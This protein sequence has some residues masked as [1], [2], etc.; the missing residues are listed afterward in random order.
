VQQRIGSADTPIMA[1]RN[2]IIA[3]SLVTGAALELFVAAVSGRRE[4]WDSEQF[5]TMG[6]PAA[7]LAS[8]VIGFVSQRREWLWAFLV[9]PGQVMTMM[10]RTG[11]I[12]NLWPLTLAASAVLSLP[13][14][15]A[16]FVGSLARP[17]RGSGA[18]EARS[19]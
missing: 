17:K 19:A 2:I 13:F 6:L 10:A 18:P 12:G 7:L 4:A 1:S 3:L 16:A 8:L 9:A 15:F 14:V 11:E 5:W